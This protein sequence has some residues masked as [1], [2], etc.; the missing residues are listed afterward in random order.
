VKIELLYTHKNELENIEPIIQKVGNISYASEREATEETAS[1]FIS[2]N[3]I[4]KHHLPLLKHAWLT[5]VASECFKELFFTLP[6]NIKQYL[7]V[8]N[9]KYGRVIVSANLNAWYNLYQLRIGPSRIL[10]ELS[11]TLFTEDTS[12]FLQYEHLKKIP[13]EYKCYTFKCDNVSRGF[14]HEIVRHGWNIAYNQRSTRYVNEKNFTF[15]PP[16][17][18]RNQTLVLDGNGYHVDDIPDLF[19]RIYTQLRIQDMPKEDARQYLPIGINAPIGITVRR[20]TLITTLQDMRVLGT[21][22][23]PHWEIKKVC[24]YLLSMV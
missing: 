14:T 19:R 21:T 16:P 7:V 8:N 20:E 6:D 15:I 4:K 23:R 5:V 2:T 18:K 10:K 9:W 1:K 17:S 24:E 13:S 11:P 12:D 3:I 22:G